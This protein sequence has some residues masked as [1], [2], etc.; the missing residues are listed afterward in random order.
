MAAVKNSACHSAFPFASD[1]LRGDAEVAKAA[2]KSFR[3]AALY[4]S[5][6]GKD[7]KEIIL[8]AVKKDG[9]YFNQASERLRKDNEVVLAALMNTVDAYVLPYLDKELQEELG[10]QSSIVFFENKIKEGKKQKRLKMK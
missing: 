1:R 6:E 3:D 10:G 2:I 7:N 9:S 4:L 8:Y 5:E